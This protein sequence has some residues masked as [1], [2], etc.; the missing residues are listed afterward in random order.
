MSG[1]SLRLT[2]KI[3]AIGII[4]VAGVVL[5]GGMHMY[6]ESAIAV[7]RDA[8]DN[9]RTLSELNSKIGIELLEGR[10]AEK[11][12]L[13]RNDQK[14]ADSQVEIG[15]SAVADIDVL[16][17]KI[18]A[19]GKPDLARQVE[20]MSGSLTQY[21]AHFSSVVE[22]K[23]RIGLDEKSGLEGR[24]RNSV[25]DI[26]ARVDQLHELPLLV[27]MLMIAG[28]RRTSCFGATPNTATR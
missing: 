26:E 1:F 11:D 18:M 7:Y 4:G 27:S 21:Q 8:A 12:F 25:H 13:L 9:A 5:V 15:K 14:R 6:G 28:T 19:A 22:E 16:H 2:H 10:R 23:V 17:G 3:T 24:L 20:A